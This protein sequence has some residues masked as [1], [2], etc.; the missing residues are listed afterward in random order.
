MHMQ[1]RPCRSGTKA[2]RRLRSLIPGDRN[3]AK[4]I[5]REKPTH[6]P[7]RSSAPTTPGRIKGAAPAVQGAP[8][9]YVSSGSAAADPAVTAYVLAAGRSRV[10]APEQQV[11]LS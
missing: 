9:D 1:S 5:A 8:V 3:V 6:P 11:R 4:A 7:K 2:R 10:S